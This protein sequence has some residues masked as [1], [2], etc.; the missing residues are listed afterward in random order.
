MLGKIPGRSLSGSEQY[1]LSQEKSCSKICAFQTVI[2]DPD[3][4]PNLSLCI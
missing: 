4:L 1:H 2:I 3:R